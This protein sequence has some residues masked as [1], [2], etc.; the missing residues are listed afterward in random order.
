MCC[1]LVHQVYVHACVRVSVRASVHTCW[2][3]LWVLCLHVLCVFMY[4]VCTLALG[5]VCTSI[6]S[7]YAANVFKLIASWLAKYSSVM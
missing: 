1:V 2:V 5:I 6:S 4:V 7:F 3:F